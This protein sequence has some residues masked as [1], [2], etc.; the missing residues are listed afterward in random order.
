MIDLRLS[1]P[2]FFENS[3]VPVILSYIAPIEIGAI[4]LG[5]FVFSKG[6]LDDD[7]RRHETIH[8]Q[9]YIE[10]LLI[11]FPLLYLYFWL[12]GWFKYGNKRTAYL[13]IPFEQEAYCNEH[14]EFYLLN[15]QPLLLLLI[16]GKHHLSQLYTEKALLV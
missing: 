10:T 15:R 7:V 12:R 14:K 3:K 11:G 2:F 4:T 5:P 9:Q 13:L 6:V 1:K 8:W 16:E